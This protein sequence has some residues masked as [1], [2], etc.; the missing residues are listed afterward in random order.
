[1]STLAPVCVKNS[2]SINVFICG[3]IPRDKSLSV[4]RVLI[5]DVNR[6]LKYL[7]LKH[8]F[9]FKDQSNGWALPNGDLDPSLFL[10]DS[11]QIIEEGNVKLV[12]WII[13]SI[14]LT[15]NICISSSTGQRYSYSDTCKNKTSITFALT[16]NEADFPPLTSSIHTHKCK[17]SPYS[18][19]CNRDLCETHGSNYVSSTSKPV[20][21]KTVCKPVLRAYCEL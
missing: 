17:H 6:I 15:N 10:R 3:L 9:S 2:S 21:S 4:D 16:L 14:A 8:D 5:K 18:N 20:S 13:N 12:K 11:F 1:M 7:C 19:N